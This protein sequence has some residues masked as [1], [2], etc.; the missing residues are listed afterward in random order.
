M[1]KYLFLALFFSLFV[2]GQVSAFAQ[3]QIS[4]KKKQLIFE[5]IKVS[6]ME[7]QMLETMQLVIDSQKTSYRDIIIDQ[8]DSRSDLSDPERAELVD[9]MPAFEE[10]IEKSFIR[11]KKEIDFGSLFRV[12]FLPVFDKYYTEEDLQVIIDFYDSPTGQKLL[13]SMAPMGKEVMGI[14]EKDLIPKLT[15]ITE[16]EVNATLKRA[17]PELYEET[18]N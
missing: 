9:K 12:S 16:E 18:D 13:D 5:F 1:K 4:D 14:M 7:E 2:L 11:I 10:M 3:D 8:V 6:R 15:K 17:F